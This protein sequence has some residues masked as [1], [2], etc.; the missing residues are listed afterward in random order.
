LPP[1]KK[2][3]GRQTHTG[4]RRDWEQTHEI[5]S[6]KYAAF[7]MDRANNP[8]AKQPT[9]AQ[10]AG[11]A[12]VSV[13]T[14]ER[15]IADLDRDLNM[16]RRLKKYRLMTD[17]AVKG[18][19]KGVG[20]G[21]ADSIRLWFEVVEGIKIGQME[22]TPPPEEGPGVNLQL[23]DDQELAEYK[24]LIKKATGKAEVGKETDPGVATG[25]GADKSPG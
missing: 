12:K 22:R 10:L 19:M 11:L 21:S 14:V 25:H 24:R 2:G 20:K 13:K 3:S 8:M 16:A 7:M 9:M 4:R 23:L 15:H 1:G 5:L 6:E 18:L 17:F